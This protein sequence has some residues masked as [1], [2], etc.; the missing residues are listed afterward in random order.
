[1]LVKN[2]LKP[3]TQVW[4]KNSLERSKSYY[5]E[6]GLEAVP[7]TLGHALAYP[8]P[9]AV[10]IGRTLLSDDL[11]KYH[12]M[13]G[14]TLSQIE[15]MTIARALGHLHDIPRMPSSASN[16]ESLEVAVLQGILYGYDPCCIDNYVRSRYLGDHS[17]NGS[18]I[19][20]PI[21]HDTWPDPHILCIDHEG[22]YSSRYPLPEGPE[23]SP[24][25]L[26]G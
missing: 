23:Y 21:N 9:A 17:R 2:G 19:Y 3:G 22:E 4:G 1:M 20:A 18:D 15:H 16:M 7:D 13:L 10:V 12:E 25:L 26:R 5:D 6:A 11:S 14:P 8:T 24:W